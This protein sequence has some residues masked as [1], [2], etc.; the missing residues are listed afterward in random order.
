MAK[1]KKD[2]GTVYSEKTLFQLLRTFD[3]QMSSY[4]D[5]E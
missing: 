3:L 5:I 1:K 2:K 4:K